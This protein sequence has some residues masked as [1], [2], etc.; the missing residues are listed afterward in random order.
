MADWKKTT[1]SGIGGR[2]MCGIIACRTDTPA[3]TTFWLR[4]GDSSTGVTTR[5]GRCR[6]TT[7]RVARLRSIEASVPWT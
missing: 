3:S 5:S 1:V 6:T 2:V 4:Y 7:G